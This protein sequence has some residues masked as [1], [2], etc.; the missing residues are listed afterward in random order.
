L[1]AALA[2]RT[3]DIALDIARYGKIIKDANIKVE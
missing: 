3:F 2:R 1:A